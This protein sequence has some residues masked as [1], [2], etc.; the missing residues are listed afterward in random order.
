MSVERFR[1]YAAVYVLLLKENSVFLLRRFNTGWQDGM[2]T[3]PS[4]HLE[5][6]EGMVVSAIRE[7]REEAGVDVSV[8]DMRFAHA[9]HRIRLGERE[10]L[11]FFFVTEKWQGDAHNSEEDKADDGQFFP[12]DALPENMIDSVRTAI[13]HYRSGVPFSEF[14]WDGRI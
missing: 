8:E 11:D 4:G 13:E 2:Y 14:G 3:L 1:P 12:L 10:Y 6:E 5:K 7:T 9:M